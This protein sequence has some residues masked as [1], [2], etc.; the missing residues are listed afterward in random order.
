MG[1]LT[2]QPTLEQLD[3]WLVPQRHP[4]AP[5]RGRDPD[6]ELDAICQIFPNIRRLVTR[7]DEPSPSAHR[8]CPTSDVPP[9]RLTLDGT[10]IRVN[11]RTAAQEAAASARIVHQA[12]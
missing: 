1:R 11:C 12:A 6:E 8:S 2:L 5:L 9:K 3:V 10:S 4:A 7:D